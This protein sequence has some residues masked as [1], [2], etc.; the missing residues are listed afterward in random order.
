[1]SGID[2]NSGNGSRVDNV[3]VWAIRMNGVKLRCSWGAV[4]DLE[5]SGICEVQ[6]EYD[7]MLMGKWSGVESID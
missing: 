3:C 2:N 1:M 6:E 4:G 7:A 5:W